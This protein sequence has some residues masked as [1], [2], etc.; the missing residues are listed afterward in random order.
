M[1]FKFQTS[2]KYDVEIITEG[3][4]VVLYINGK[5]ALTNRIYARDKNRW[6]LIAEGQNAIITNLQVT[7]PE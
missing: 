7:Q 3:S 6:G 1:P 2:T 5:V 4:I